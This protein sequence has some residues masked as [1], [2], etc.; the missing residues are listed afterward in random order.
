MYITLHLFPNRCGSPMSFRCQHLD[1]EV[2][3]ECNGSSSSV[4]KRTCAQSL[5]ETRNKHE[6]TSHN[7]QVN[8][9]CQ[10]ILRARSRTVSR[11]EQRPRIRSKKM[12][13]TPTNS[14]NLV[15]RQSF[16]QELCWFRS[17]K[18]L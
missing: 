16:G 2:R 13:R 5:Y 14:H 12:C 8:V 6:E 15:N 11:R 1:A 4:T 17:E 7:S 10:H 3:N 18:L 9:L